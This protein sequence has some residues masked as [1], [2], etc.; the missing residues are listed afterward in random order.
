MI[1]NVL[2][3]FVSTLPR[4]TL[5]GLCSN[6]YIDV[7]YTMLLDEETNMPYIRGFSKARCQICTFF[8]QICTFFVL[9]KKLSNLHL[10]L[11]NLHLFSHQKV[12]KSAPFFNIK[13]SKL[14]SQPL[15]GAF[16][17][18]AGSFSSPCGELRPNLTQSKEILQQ[19][20]L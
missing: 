17:A 10:F 18:L 9:L 5:R 4:S 6:D 12:V 7:F 3:I 11:S 16:L 19:K 20:I 13:W 15:Q 2:R 1:E 14:L 8:C